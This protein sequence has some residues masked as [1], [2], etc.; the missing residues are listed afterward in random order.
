MAGTQ[1]VSFI[2]AGTIFA[3]W[4]ILM[5]VYGVLSE[6]IERRKNILH[7][8]N[9]KLD[10]YKGALDQVL[11]SI[12][13][14][15]KKERELDKRMAVLDV[16]Y[17]ARTLTKLKLLGVLIAVLISI[18]LHNFLAFFPLLLI[19]ISLPENYV[20]A[21]INNKLKLFDDQVLEA[22]QI[23]ITDY[24]TTKSVQ[25]TLNNICPKLKYP[26]R[27]EF[28]L[29]ARKL[30]AG[31]NVEECFL[32][33][34]ERTQN[35]WIM[36]FSQ[37]MITYFRNGGD[38]TPHLLNITHNITSERILKEQNNT[39]LSLLRTL[40]ILMNALIPIAYISNY[41][42]NPQNASVFITTTGGRIVIFIVLMASLLSLYL[43]KKITE[44]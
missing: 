24:T 8:I 38:F 27:R 15:V 2:V 10:I 36:I 3:L 11:D 12:D 42:I 5:V 30:N 41:Y 21:K 16:K 25:K 39:E 17:T 13:F 35:K 28:E 32:S 9:S 34:A 18:H 4:G 40:N 33:F 26:L 20:E 31:M 1:T 43:G 19:C 29:L 23:F 7:K 14:I 44:M 6:N 22:F 37:L